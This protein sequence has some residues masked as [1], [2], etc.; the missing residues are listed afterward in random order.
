[1]RGK[2]GVG[3]LTRNGEKVTENS[4]DKAEEKL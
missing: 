3:A 1:M 2:I 4:D